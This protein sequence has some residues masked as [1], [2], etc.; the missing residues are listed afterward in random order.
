MKS[1][2]VLS[3]EQAPG[4]F[5]KWIAC[6]RVTAE[7]F[8]CLAPVVLPNPR[9]HSAHHHFPQCH[10]KSLDPIPP[11]ICDC[12]GSL[13]RGRAIGGGR[14]FSVVIGKEWKSARGREIAMVTM[15]TSDGRES[16]GRREWEGQ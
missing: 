15:I 16:G 4:R 7:E 1:I 13:G 8:P 2:E 9:G 14:A 10:I 12:D 11:V 5:L 3:P 6:S